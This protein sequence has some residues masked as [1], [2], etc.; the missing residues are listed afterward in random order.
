VKDYS[1][2]IPWLLLQVVGGQ[3]GP[4]GGDTLTA[5]TY[6]QRVHT[7]GGIAPATGC[8]ESTD[9]GKK[10]LVPYEADYYFYRYRDS[11]WDDR[12]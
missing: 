12:H 11:D 5:S 10:V 6:I 8:A 4:T 1:G 2:A 7:A 9:V 3:D